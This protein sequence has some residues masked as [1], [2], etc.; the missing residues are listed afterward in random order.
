[1][2]NGE[3][4]L[5]NILKIRQ[6]RL[7]LLL[8]I[9]MAFLL[10]VLARVIRNGAEP[11]IL[12]IQ[13]FSTL[14]VLGIC[15]STIYLIYSVADTRGFKLTVLC[16]SASIM[17]GQL[18]NVL[19]GMPSLDYLFSGDYAGDLDLAEGV[20]SSLGLVLLLV[21]V[22]M[23]LLQAVY[24][25]WQLQ[26]SEGKF[27]LLSIQD[28]LTGLANRGRLDVM[29][30]EEWLRSRREKLTIS[31]MLI[32]IDS[33]KSYNDTLGHQAGDDA[34]QQVGKVL[35]QYTRRPG[36]LPCRYGGEEFA[37][38]LPNTKF[39]GAVE[40]G[41]IIRQGVEALRLPHPASGTAD[42]LTVSVGVSSSSLAAAQDASS[43][44]LA[45]DKALYRSKAQ[46]RNRVLAA[47]DARV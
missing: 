5:Q 9:L 24:M 10:H 18:L 19:S 23:A 16:A 6:L 30:Q 26:L 34:L 42:I 14:A 20:L 43:L 3:D 21:A 38:I 28:A 7:R 46:G 22:F 1:M 45:A 44:V 11:N 37:I 17:A 13:I 2:S 39:E 15:G 32:D 27:K 8:I 29:L 25:K 47:M 4:A 33:F 31:F 36:D 35:R 41:E 12:L 40:L